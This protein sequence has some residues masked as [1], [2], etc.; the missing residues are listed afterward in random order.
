MKV[1]TFHT[2]WKL[3]EFLVKLFIGAKE[4]KKHFCR[5]IITTIKERFVMLVEIK[6]SGA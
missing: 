5:G 1:E 6:P 2:H 3:S 4:V